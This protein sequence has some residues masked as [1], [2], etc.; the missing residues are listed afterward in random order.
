[1]IGNEIDELIRE[2]LTDGFIS[3]VERQVLL[4][5]AESLGMDKDE[6]SLYIDAQQQK[7]DKAKLEAAVKKR[8]RSCPYCGSTVPLLS[9]KCP[10]C[11]HILTVEV[12]DEFQDIVDNLEEALVELKAGKDIARS[13]A[14]VE[15]Y[16]RKAKLYYGNNPKVQILLKE[17]EKEL[18]DT[19]AKKRKQLRTDSLKSSFTKLTKTVFSSIWSFIIRH[20]GWSVVIALLLLILIYP[21]VEDSQLRKQEHEQSIRQEQFT[22]AIASGDLNRAEELA[23]SWSQSVSVA[24]EYL[25]EGNVDNAFRIVGKGHSAIHVLIED[26]YISRG[27]Y[28]KAIGVLDNPRFYT[29]ELYALLCKCVDHMLGLNDTKKVK[30][31]I[32]GNVFYFDEDADTY[33]KKLYEYAGLY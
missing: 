8:G 10:E 29:T 9:D 32:D 2:F 24:Q 14:A 3:D 17:I 13:K 20:P 22:N 26:Y 18:I 11:D 25:K 6:V 19:E 15:R 31:F 4:R 21:F 5:K 28:S 12:N 1:M 30:R 16:V 7:V 27:D 23:G 33:K